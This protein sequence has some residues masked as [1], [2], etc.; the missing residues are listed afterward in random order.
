[1]EAMA[2]E[3]ALEVMLE[4]EVKAEHQE[5]AA[6]EVM[7]VTLALVAKAAVLLKHQ[8]ANHLLLHILNEM[9]C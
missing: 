5:E 8:A 2:V 6:M 9:N 3:P 1:M 7:V 4:N